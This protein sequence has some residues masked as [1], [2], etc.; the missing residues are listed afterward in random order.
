V[1]LA[2]RI[3]AAAQ[4]GKALV[5][6]SSALEAYGWLDEARREL[7]D[8]AV[9]EYAARSFA[10]LGGVWGVDAG[11]TFY[12]LEKLRATGGPG[13][14]VLADT[15]FTPVVRERLPSYPELRIIEGN[16]G[17]AATV[18]QVGDVDVVFLFD[19]LLHQVN[20]DWNEILELY[21]PHTQAF[22]IH[23]QQYTGEH[24]VRLLDLGEEKY[25][26][27]AY[28]GA[29]VD[30]EQPP[31][32]RLFE[33]LD[34]ISPKHGRPW[35]DIHEIWQWGITDGDLV[36]KLGSL[37]F[38]LDCFRNLRRFK[39]LEWFERHAFAFSRSGK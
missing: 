15:D 39:D 19:T 26:R 27:N 16:F 17:D 25:F 7:I 18:E 8:F 14:G 38:T 4:R 30:R 9:S 31:Y 21:A 29:G 37:G 11:Y 24:T 33:K 6:P 28:R 36:A 23:N 20:P 32:D 13:A 35:R 10:D 12:A 3:R 1:T 22:L 5:R 2:M 34:E